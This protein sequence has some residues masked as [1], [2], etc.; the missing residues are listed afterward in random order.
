MAADVYQIITDR[1]IEK[2]EAGTPPWRKPWRTAGGKAQL[3]ANLASKRDYRGVNVFLLHAAGYASP[4]WLSYKQ[5]AEKGG[6][7]R[8]GEKGFP[9]VF[10]K[11]LAVKDKETGK[12]KQVPLLRYYTVFNSEQID[13]LTLPDEPA[14]AGP[15]IDPVDAA[16]AIA[17]GYKDGPAVRHG[18]RQAAYKPGADEVVM[19]D[20]G[21]FFTPSGY[22][23]TLFH[24]LGHST[25]HDKRLGRKGITEPHGYGSATYSQEELVAEMTAA[26]LLGHCGLEAPELD[27]AAAYIQGWLKALKD[28]RKLVVVAAAQAQKAA[29]HILGIT[30]EAKTEE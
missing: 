4:W 18:F 14:E 22:Y 13:G 19:P 16:E 6:Q 3:P 28:D 9:V 21:T 29:D 10:W 12:D 1:I 5:A 17:A 2:L 30:H 26:F 27:N 7:V 23:G 11:P 20:M 8:K 24:E 25:G 15:G